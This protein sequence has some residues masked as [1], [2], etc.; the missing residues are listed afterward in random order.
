MVPAHSKVEC[1][2]NSGGI[3]FTVTCVRGGFNRRYARLGN[4]ISIVSY[5]RKKYSKDVTKELSLKFAKKIK[6]K[7]IKLK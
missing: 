5:R 1:A 6:K 3:W 7:T 2:D 4:L